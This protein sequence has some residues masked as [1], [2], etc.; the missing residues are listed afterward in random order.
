MVFGIP[1]VGDLLGT[2]CVHD[3]W[4]LGACAAEQHHDDNRQ[5]SG[6]D[7]AQNVVHAT[8]L[9]HGHQLGD[10]ETDD[11]HP[12]NGSRKKETTSRKGG[13]LRANLGSNIGNHTSHLIFIKKKI[14][15]W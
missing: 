2:D 11:I 9:G 13:G 7:G 4:L 10:D 3:R 6:E 1:L 12:G 14:L 8:I 5:Q 15:F